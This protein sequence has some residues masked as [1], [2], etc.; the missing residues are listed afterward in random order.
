MNRNLR[1]TVIAVALLMTL[2]WTVAGQTTDAGQATSG[3][4]STGQGDVSLFGGGDFPGGYLKY[5]Y[6]IT[7]QGSDLASTTSTEITPRT[8]GNYSVVSTST[9]TEPLDM[10]HVGFFG[11]ALPRLGIHV[12]ENTSG[13]IDLS[14]LS[15]ISSSEIEPG[16]SYLLPDGGRFD[17]GDL[18]TIAGIQVV[19]GTYTR[20]TTATSRSILP[21]Q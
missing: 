17:A 5:T 2:G 13:T 20:P 11:V 18:G 7:R 6:S 19:Y 21:S 9:E 15:T 14:P 12:E 16:K 4:G 10:V 8:D 3:S 1:L